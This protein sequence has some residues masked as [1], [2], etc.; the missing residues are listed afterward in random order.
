M[1]SQSPVLFGLL[2]TLVGATISAYYTYLNSNVARRTKQRDLY[3]M[4]K[5]EFLNLSRHCKISSDEIQASDQISLVQ[6]RKA[7]YRDGGVIFLDTKELYLLNENL[8]QDVMQVILYS[9]NTDIE[10]D[11]MIENI[12]CG[13]IETYSKEEC[14][15]LIRR[16]NVSTKIAAVVIAH[17]EIFWKK[18]DRYNEPQI[19][20]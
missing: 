7:R 8:C 10:I 19:N 13:K 17:M 2:G 5:A 18:P 11:Q 12:K 14:V 4:I 1:S 20:W 9:R 6:L 16:L 15:S 3:R